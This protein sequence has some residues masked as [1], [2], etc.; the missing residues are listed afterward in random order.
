MHFSVLAAITSTLRPHACILR[1]PKLTWKDGLEINSR[2]GS[3]AQC[4][5]MPDSPPPHRKTECRQRIVTSSLHHDQGNR[6]DGFGGAYRTQTPT[7]SFRA[8]GHG[9]GGIQTRRPQHSLSLHAERC[10]SN[11]ASGTSWRICRL[12]LFTSCSAHPPRSG[13]SLSPRTVARVP[14]QICLPRH[15]YTAAVSARS[16]TN[17]RPCLMGY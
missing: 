13:P 12:P 9:T 14:Q 11:A 3:D 16:R 1:Y 6:C 5:C 8:S 7:P 10:I 17:Q 2:S 4:R 15:A